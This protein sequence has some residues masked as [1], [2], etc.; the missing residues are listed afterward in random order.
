MR[1]L[2]GF[3]GFQ[4]L[5]AALA[6]SFAFSAGAI[7]APPG[8]SDDASSD[9]AARAWLRKIQSS[10]QRLNYAGTFVYQQAGQV[11]T[12]RIAHIF[13]GKT[14]LEKLEILDGRPR[15]YVRRGE[16]VSSYIPESK[17]LI[18]ERRVTKDI[19]PSIFA[20]DPATLA[21]HYA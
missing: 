17:L 18:V 6:V 19:F 5:R 3:T 1:P 15:E 21:D 14:E 12:S 16:E 9:P 2:F 13:D 7:A 11:R 8:A 10:A 4:I 20:A